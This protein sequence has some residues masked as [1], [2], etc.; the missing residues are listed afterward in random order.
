MVNELRDLLREA[1]DGGPQ[2]TSD[3]A[4]VLRTGRRRVRVRRARVLGGTALATAASVAV[5]SFVLA[6]PDPVTAE[7]AGVP[8][9]EGPVLRLADAKQAK[10]GRD[11]RVVTSYTN[12]N[13]DRENG[14]YLDGV[15]DDGL[16][17]FRDGPR[18]TQL[19]PRY[20]LMDPVTEEKDWLPRL[21]VGQD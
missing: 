17:L 20:A 13:L 2:D 11:Y 6:D 12:E 14:Q 3:L 1:A 8:R 19:Y 16:V 4:P 10:E 9:A 5:T 21:D 15:T 18:R 7:P